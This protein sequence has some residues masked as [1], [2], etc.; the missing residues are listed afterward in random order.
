M[1][2]IRAIGDLLFSTQRIRLK[3]LKNVYINMCDGY[4]IQGQSK[5]F[6]IEVVSRFMSF[7]SDNASEGDTRVPLSLLVSR[8]QLLYALSS[9][10]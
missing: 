9:H 2:G 6:Y 1:S 7:F 4:T 5:Y 10:F 3:H 8:L